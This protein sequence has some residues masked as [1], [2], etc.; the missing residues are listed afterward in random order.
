MDL[1]T[2]DKKVAFPVLKVQSCLKLPEAL[3]HVTMLR[4]P[5]SK[6]P[7]IDGIAGDSKSMP[8]FNAT[9]DPHHNVMMLNATQKHGLL[10]LQEKYQQGGDSC[11]HYMLLP[12]EKFP[13]VAK[14]KANKYVWS[15]P[16]AE[17]FKK[18]RPREFTDEEK[19]GKRK[20]WGFSVVSIPLHK[21]NGVSRH[22]STL[23][24]VIQR[25]LR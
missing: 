1:V 9:I 13:D 2:G 23:R 16:H 20:L 12:G 7:A 14:L 25:C 18:V 17:M 24:T 5:H 10:S 19:I 8:T 15:K 21:P 4:S 11:H 22:Y 6:Y 3:A